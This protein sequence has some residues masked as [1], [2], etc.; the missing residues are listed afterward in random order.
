MNRKGVFDD[1][2]VRDDENCYLPAFLPW[3]Y[4]QS[5]LDD[6]DPV[7]PRMIQQYHHPAYV[8]FQGVA[9][10]GLVGVIP[11]IPIE[12]LSLSSHIVNRSDSSQ[13]PAHAYMIPDIAIVYC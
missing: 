1:C 8:Q 4:L 2:V 10:E 5:V 3:R 6:I 7:Y 11:A 9:A 12:S 13:P